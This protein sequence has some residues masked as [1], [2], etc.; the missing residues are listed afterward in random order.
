MTHAGFAVATVCVAAA[1]AACSSSSQPDVPG[2]VAVY[3]AGE[4]AAGV[5]QPV[6]GLDS[7]RIT[8]ARLLVRSFRV[9]PSGASYDLTTT[10]RV[11]DVPLS[12]PPRLAFSGSAPLTAFSRVT[13][14]LRPLA[15]SE[16][17]ALPE[18]LQA[19]FTDFAQQAE[20]T[21]LIV[22]GYTRDGETITPFRFISAIKSTLALGLT[23]SVELTAA[24]PTTSLTVIANVSAWFVDTGGPLDP[25]DPANASTIAANVQRALRVIRDENHDGVAD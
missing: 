16:L 2:R 24:H 10:P 22:D 3:V 4:A 5:V 12:G 6:A 15:D 21:S 19:P 1:F 8:R 7:V 25:T 17:T 20:V 13:C 14:E 23:P 18:S 11:L 9:T